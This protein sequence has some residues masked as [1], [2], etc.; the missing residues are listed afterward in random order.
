MTTIEADDVDVILDAL[1]LR[2]FDLSRKI[3]KHERKEL[4]APDYRRAQQI[5]I[6]LDKL[7]SAEA[8][9]DRLEHGATV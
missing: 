7:E 4:F 9:L 1:S 2:I 8:V 5:Q 3:D 6:Y